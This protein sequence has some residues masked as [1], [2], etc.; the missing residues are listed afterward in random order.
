MRSWLH[1]LAAQGE[2]EEGSGGELSAVS[3][4][5]GGCTVRQVC[6]LVSSLLGICMYVYTH[7]PDDSDSSGN[8]I[9]TYSE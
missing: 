2:E 4:V 9:A 1:A 3:G 8:G 6:V 7:F 5:M